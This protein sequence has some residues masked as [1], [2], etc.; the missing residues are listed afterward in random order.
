MLARDRYFLRDA[1]AAGVRCYACA[2]ALAERRRG[3]A[4]IAEMTGIAGAATVVG[5]AVRSD[6]RVMVF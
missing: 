2:M 5:A 4:L 1:S 6:W 3:E